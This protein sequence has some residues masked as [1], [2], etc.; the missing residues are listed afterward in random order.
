MSI[1]Q[2]SEHLCAVGKLQTVCLETNLLRSNTGSPLAPQPPAQQDT[3]TVFGYDD[4]TM[5]KFA[6]ADAAE[7]A[8]RLGRRR[9]DT[10]SHRPTD[11]TG[12]TALDTS[13]Q[14]GIPVKLSKLEQGCDTL[15]NYKSEDALELVEDT[16]AGLDEEMHTTE[17]Y[18]EEDDDLDEEEEEE[19]LPSSLIPRI[20]IGDAFQAEIPDY[21]PDRVALE[22]ETEARETLLWFPANLDDRDPKNIESLNLLMKIACSP[23]VRSCGLNMEYTFHLLC[24]YKGNLEMTLH[25]LLYETLVVYDYVYAE[26]TAWTTE[27]I[28]RFQHGLRL[29]GRD[30]HQVAKDLQ[31]NGMNKT[32]KA[33]VEFYYV[34]KRMNTP[35]DVKWYRER[36]RRQRLARGD[37]PVASEM[38]TQQSNN[39]GNVTKST[40]NQPSSVTDTERLGV[41]T[42]NLR[43]KPPAA[44]ADNNHLS[45]LV[46]K[47]AD[48]AQL[49]DLASL[50][51]DNLPVYDSHPC[52]EPPDLSLLAQ[53]EEEFNLANGSDGGYPCHICHRVFSK[54]KSRS[55]HMKS[56]SDR[57]SNHNTTTV[58]TRTPTPY[59][60]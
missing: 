11:T 48:V 25:A 31:A 59:A 43:R 1:G 24:K 27:E 45:A 21:C 3:S 38:E 42:Y 20:N 47:T 58:H 10:D 23:A 22:T 17:L 60:K 55:A 4:E 2:N 49:E 7:R 32:V 14:D 19:G 34:W 40:S 46:E 13:R 50:G 18:I 29:Y 12:K 33:C 52:D 8:R 28:A 26:T 51:L 36:A 57:S 5:R 15:M 53:V 54:V 6:E 41:S 37:V 44:K 30:F 39:H 9:C 35:S 16:L 56:H